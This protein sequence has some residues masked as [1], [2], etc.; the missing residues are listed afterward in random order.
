MKFTSIRHKLIFFV[1]LFITVLLLLIA[2]GVYAYF[3]HTT[4]EQVFSQQFQ[5]VSVTAKGLDDKIRS[6]HNALS[7][8]AEVAPIES[9]KNRP[10]L[11]NWL[12][13]RKGLLTIFNHGLFLLDA[14]GDLNIYTSGL[15]H[16]KPQYFKKLFADSIRSNGQRISTPIICS[17]NQHPIIVM[18][19][20]V[21]DSSGAIKGLLCGAV[22][23]LQTNSLFQEIAQTRLGS[24]GYMYIFANDRTMV[25]H[26][27][28]SRIG[29][30]AV[31]PGINKIFDRALNGFEGSGENINSKGMHFL[32]SVKRLESTDW[33]LAANYPY[34]E[35]MQPIVSFR[36]VFVLSTLL[37]LF[38]GVFM[39][40]RL[41]S[42]I[43]RPLSELTAQIQEMSKP[44]ANREQFLSSTDHGEIAVLTDSF[45]ALLHELRLRE[46]ELHLQAVFLEQ[47]IAER[48]KSEIL[49]AEQH[50]E[51]LATEEMLRV[52]IEEY[53]IGQKL[54][55]ESNQRF[56]T[57]HD[58]SFGGI[59]IHDK[60]VILDCNHGLSTITGFTEEALIGMNLVDLID[61][62]YQGEVLQNIRN[63]FEQP[64]EVA[65]IR[66]DGSSYYLRIHSKN[67]PYQERTVQVSELRDISES[68]HAEEARLTLERQFQHAQKL[69]SLGVLS[70]GIAH[71]L[72]NI[73]TIIMAQCFMAKA[74]F[75][76]VETYK[77]RIQQIEAAGR[78]AADLCRQMLIYAGKS[79]SEL[80]HVNMWL[81]V[82]EVVKM[83]S[84]AIKKNVSI[85]L[86]LKRNVPTL[87][88]DDA[89]IQQVV[90]N[91]IIN[92]AD[93]I[94][95]NNGTVNVSLAR[96]AITADLQETDFAGNTITPGDYCCLVVTDDGC[97]M[98]AKTQ[99][100]IFEPFFTTKFTGRGL[101]MSAI[102][103][104]IK[105]HNGAL[106]LSSEPGVG[107]T[108]KVYLPLPVTQEFAENVIAEETVTSSET[109]GTVLLVDDEE[110][111][112]NVGADIL[113]LIGFTVV[114]AANGREALEI[115]NQR[116]S[117]I[118]LVMLDLIM[119]VMGGIDAFHELRKIS[120]TIPVVICSGYGV[121]EI[122][123]S[124]AHDDNTRFIKKPYRPEQLR[125]VLAG[126]LVVKS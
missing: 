36:N 52:Q 94:G 97:G 59:C 95:E 67:I 34:K 8:V 121:E 70:G 33:I 63:S 46:G 43:T 47:E 96:I 99:G 112:R 56:K 1:S 90:M 79:T 111:L 122:E 53:E 98:D 114:T 7:A 55:K 51:L 64:Y 83:L 76:S 19:A 108:F 37:V 81:L 85:L 117:E 113:E 88:G 106:Q 3:R 11:Q 73:L 89:Q 31:A 49:Q 80:T 92:A 21:K 71:D 116:Q 107:T 28:S 17:N 100:R 30:L 78:R 44:D 61:L 45:N 25:V 77:D 9:L 87:C 6:S 101:G 29:K 75:K 105:A 84:A 86:D 58:A 93:A 123:N 26:N 60:D 91:L 103:G 119:P 126:M 38:V 16:E 69:E 115:Y 68:K 54:L 102:L 57:L 118:N 74:D 48:Q 39:A 124:I 22:D 10:E 32:T 62:K 5:M 27:D 20:P 82:D 65:G 109:T 12:D 42:S 41:G 24:S 13:N 125:S 72:N 4:R 23:L 35:A 120:S 2:V 50:D 104:I 40:R 14:N 110:I 15:K 66:K 18:T